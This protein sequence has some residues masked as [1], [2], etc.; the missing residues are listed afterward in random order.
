MPPD[1]HGARRGGAQPP[2]WPSHARRWSAA[3]ASARSPPSFPSPTPSRTTAATR[4]P[5]PSSRPPSATS[6]RVSRRTS[7]EASPTPLNRCHTDREPGMVIWI[8]GGRSSSTSATDDVG[9]CSSSGDDDGGVRA[10]AARMSSRK[11]PRKAP[12]LPAK[13]LGL[14]DVRGAAASR[15][16]APSASRC[17]V[18]DAAASAL[19]WRRRRERRP[20]PSSS[21]SSPPPPL[22]PWK[23]CVDVTASSETK[24]KTRARRDRRAV[25]CSSSLGRSAGPRGHR[26]SSGE[27][28]HGA[29]WRSDPVPLPM[30]WSEL[31]LED[32]VSNVL[33]GRARG[34]AG[35]ATDA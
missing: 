4:C 31:E 13:R 25:I 22:P 16:R 10:R 30:L 18:G 19:S 21:S 24:A 35:Q 29:G 23:R 27:R 7:Q 2:R 26:H 33:C 1:A 14:A 20:V 12:P 32:D 6:R 28:F 17:R 5:V 11:E 9:G 34:P 3:S 15:A 8:R